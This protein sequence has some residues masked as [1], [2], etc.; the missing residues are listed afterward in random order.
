MVTRPEI[1]LTTIDRTF[2][3]HAA[4][5][6]PGV[7]ATILFL[8]AMATTDWVRLHYPTGL[9]RR[10]TSAYVERQISGLFRICRVECDNASV[11]VLRSQS[12][13]LCFFRPACN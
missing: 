2:Y 1:E 13:S 11:P 4:A 6:V 8:A 7:V 5:A 9:Y 12:A 10:S 3:P